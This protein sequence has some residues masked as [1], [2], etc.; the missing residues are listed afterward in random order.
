MKPLRLLLCSVLLAS[1]L[2]ALAEEDAAFG[3]VL[4]LLSAFTRIAASPIDSPRGVADLLAGKDAEANRAA[5]GLLD[6]MTADLP[7]AHRA[8]ISAIGSNLLAAARN[9]PPNLAP[10]QAAS[11]SA[12][13]QARKD[14]TAMGLRYFDDGQFLAAVSRNDALAV[15]LYIAGQGVNLSSRDARGRSALE[16]ARA[17]GNERLVGLLSKNAP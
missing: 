13:L 12:A 16:I 5:A 10:S 9:N 14:L 11:P 17:N 4:T 2:S 8:Q 15:E 6:E 1:P 3:H 7:A